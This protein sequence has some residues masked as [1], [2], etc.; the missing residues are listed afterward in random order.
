MSVQSEINRI[1]GNVTAALAKIAEKGVTVPDGANSDNLE[2]LIE[3]IEAGGGSV[4]VA[5]GTFTT[6]DD[7]TSNIVITHNLGVK[8]K[9]MCVVYAGADNFISSRVDVLSF[10]FLLKYKATNY[11]IKYLSPSNSSVGYLNGIVSGSSDGN[12]GAWYRWNIDE[13]TMTLKQSNINST[14]GIGASSDFFWIAYGE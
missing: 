11:G 14:Y 8:P 2:A 13:T 5:T 1:K 4:K 10:V 9:F 7:I 6:T 12:S 3:A